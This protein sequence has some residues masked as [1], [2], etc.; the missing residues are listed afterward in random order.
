MWKYDFIRKTAHVGSVDVM[1]VMCTWFICWFQ[2]YMHRLFHFLTHFFFLFVFFLT[3]LLL[4]LSF[5]LRLGLLCFQAESCKRQPNVVCLHLVCII[6]SLC[7]CWMVTD[8]VL[9]L[10]IGDMSISPYM[11][12]VLWLFGRQEVHPACKKTEWWDVGVVVWDEMQTCI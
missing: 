9:D 7:S 1:T 5:P 3:Y 6:V 10:V 2:H 11:P 4:Y 12:S 8:V